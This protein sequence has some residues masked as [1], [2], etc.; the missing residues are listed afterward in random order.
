M[1]DKPNFF[2]LGVNML[3]MF[4]ITVPAL[5]I[6]VAVLWNISPMLGQFI[7]LLAFFGIMSLI[8]KVRS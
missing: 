2:L 5:I 6:A 1:S 3:V 8:G 4:W 7:L